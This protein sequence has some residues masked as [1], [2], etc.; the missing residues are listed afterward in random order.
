MF[1]LKKLTLFTAI[2]LSISMVFASCKVTW[3]PAPDASIAT[4]ISEGAKQ[5]DALYLHVQE[6]TDRSYDK[7]TEEYTAAESTINSIKLKNQDRPK[8]G[9]MLKIVDNLQQAFVKYK[10]EHKA[11]G[12]I[13]VSEARLYG[14]YLQG[15][16]AALWA[17][18]R[19][20]K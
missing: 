12:K 3:S 17:A 19:Q 6:A 15:H 11:K 4:D 20:L 10:E 16:W 5:T 2:L 8:S 9:T 14:K 13:N 18:E 7:F 1:P